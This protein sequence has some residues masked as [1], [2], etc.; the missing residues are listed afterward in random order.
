MDS[1]V[2]TPDVDLI[3]RLKDGD[4][5]AFD[6]VYRIYSR[7]LYGFLFKM[8]KVEADVEEIIQEI[9]M[10]LW[11]SRQKISGA[12]GFD[13]WLFTISYNLSISHIR[14]RVSEKRYTDHLKSVQIITNHPGKAEDS[15][16]EAII[17]KVLTVIENLPARQREVFRLHRVEGL[18]HQKIAE[19]LNI[20]QNTV[21][22]HM[23][24]ALRFI[25]ENLDITRLPVMLFATLFL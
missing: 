23:G 14:K 12:E 15:D 24:R 16:Y 4:L 20:S 6:T 2:L 18:S 22:N 13:A 1:P 21:E 25:R 8:L 10:T 3:A 7:R 9:F 11:T 17:A 5:M 19:K